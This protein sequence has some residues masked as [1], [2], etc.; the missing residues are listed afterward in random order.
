MCAF[1]EVT[2]HAPRFAARVPAGSSL[3]SPP[4]QRV[5]ETLWTIQSLDRTNSIQPIKSSAHVLPG[6]AL[7]L[8]YQPPTQDYL[9]HAST[10][11][12]PVFH[13]RPSWHLFPNAPKDTTRPPTIREHSDKR[14]AKRMR[15]RRYNASAGNRTRGWPT[16]SEEKIS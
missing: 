5:D 15:S 12:W 16:L 13:Q 9:P 4:H 14:N 6:S 2:R 10:C 1:G 11:N 3:S 8:T 7:P